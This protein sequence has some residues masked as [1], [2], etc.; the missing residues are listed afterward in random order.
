MFF[1]ILRTETVQLHP[2]Y[3][4]KNFE[5]KVQI[6]LKHKVE[7]KCSGRYGYTIAVTKIFPIG[8]G[9]L[10]EDSGYAHFDVKFMSLVF[11][12]FKNE[13]LPARVSAVNTSGFFCDAGPLSIFVSKL[14]MPDEY[15]FDSSKDGLPIYYT[16]T[17][18]N[19]EIRIEKDSLVR[20]KIIGLR[21]TSSEIVTIGTIKEDYLGPFE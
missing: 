2:Q 16:R 4:G 9:R 8:K 12:P 5:E 1:H 11:R 7:G 18:D 13:V 15:K 19:E 17:E 21:L 20:V 10:H 14:L 3:F 6:E